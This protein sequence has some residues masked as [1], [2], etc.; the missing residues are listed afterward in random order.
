MSSSMYQEY[1]NHAKDIKYL[2]KV[3]NSVQIEL[4]N[5]K[6]EIDIFR[7]QI[8]YINLSLDILLDSNDRIRK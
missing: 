6:K 7:K 3:I 4:K 1:D 5:I 8:K 2:E